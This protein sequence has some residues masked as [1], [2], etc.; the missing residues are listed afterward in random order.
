MMPKV[1]RARTVTGC[2]LYAANHLAGEIPKLARV[3]RRR[4][5]KLNLNYTNFHEHDPR[6]VKR[7]I[8]GQLRFH[9]RSAWGS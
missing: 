1:V 7:N 4:H 3:Y 9:C 5:E 6:T 2:L 8:T